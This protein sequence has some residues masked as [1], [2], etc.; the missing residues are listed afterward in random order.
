M[1]PHLHLN[2]FMNGMLLSAVL[3]LEGRVGSRANKCSVRSDCPA[4]VFEPS[5]KPSVNW[6]F[7]NQGKHLVQPEVLS[8]W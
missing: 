4:D 7:T 1:E 5:G 6:L 2:V 8:V 3:R